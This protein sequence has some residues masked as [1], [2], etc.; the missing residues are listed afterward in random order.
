VR[1]VGGVAERLVDVSFELLREGVLE[2]VRF[3][4]HLVEREAERLGEVLLEQP[5]VANDLER[6][7][8]PLSGQRRA[9]IRLVLDEPELREL[10][11]HPGG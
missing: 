7:P 2:P 11:D 6:R 5:V 9:L 1:I 8:F 3:R 10:L 4:M